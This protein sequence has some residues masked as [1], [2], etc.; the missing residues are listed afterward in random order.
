MGWIIFSIWIFCG[1]TFNLAHAIGENI[2]EGTIAKKINKGVKYGALGIL[3]LTV[4]VLILYAIGW[5]WFYFCGGFLLFEDQ[6]FIDKVFCG[7]WSVVLSGFV[8]GLIAII[9]GWDPRI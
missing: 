4:V 8:F 1:I 2:P 6:P 5:V 9:F 7:L 3:A